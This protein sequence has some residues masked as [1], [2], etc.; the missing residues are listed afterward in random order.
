[1]EKNMKKAVSSSFFQASSVRKPL[2]IPPLIKPH[3]RVINP[4]FSSRSLAP[5]QDTAIEVTL[6][7]LSQDME[8]EF[9]E[10]Q[11]PKFP[12]KWQR[13][14]T[15]APKR[16][17]SISPTFVPTANKF[18]ALN[19][20]EIL[21][22]APPKLP[23]SSANPPKVRKTRVPPV[24]LSVMGEN[25]KTVIDRL[26][27]FLGEN[28]CSIQIRGPN[29]S[30]QTESV[31]A[32]KL[33]VN[34]LRDSGAVFHTFT[35]AEDRTCKVVIKGLPS[36]EPREISE[37]LRAQGFEVISVSLM[38]SRNPTSTRNPLFLVQM[39][40]GSDMQYM[41]NKVREICHVKVSLEKFRGKSNI[42]GTQCY[43][44]QQFGHSAHNCNRDARCVK[45]MDA[46]ASKECPRPKGS[47][48][49]S[50]GVRCCNCGGDHPANFR[51]CP[52][53]IAYAKAIAARRATSATPKTKAMPHKSV[54]RAADPQTLSYTAALTGP[55]TSAF[56]AANQSSP[57]SRTIPSTLVEAL[58]SLLHG[59]DGVTIDDIPAILECIKMTRSIRAEPTLSMEERLDRAE[60]LL[61][62]CGMLP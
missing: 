27:T 12:F 41:S 16:P 52:K 28:K 32:H 22:T 2:Q 15:K 21:P 8:T 10:L 5:T 19:P 54:S 61:N 46:H 47:A 4:T 33:L 25:H 49:G 30:V 58:N 1:M 44:C 60:S 34:G 39:P 48:I 55:Q 56:A 6:N 51:Q 57:H 40:P 35:L 43:R 59:E 11:I 36:I 37:D 23:P 50:P 3:D 62:K 7:S 24:I 29:Y 13:V 53:R 26:N 38:R 20:E 14:T 17:L 18:M 42:G 31:V 45:C 9:P